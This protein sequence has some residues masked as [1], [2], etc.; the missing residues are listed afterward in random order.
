VLQAHFTDAGAAIADGLGE[1][2]AVYSAAG[3]SF[4]LSNAARGGWPREEGD[5]PTGRGGPKDAD[6]ISGRPA[7]PAPDEAAKTE[8][9]EARPLSLE[10]RRNN[11]FVIPE[12]RRP[13]ALLRFGD[14]D[15]L[16]L[17]GLLRHGGELARRAAVV[18]VPAGKGRLLLFAINPIWRGETIGTH[19]LVWNSV[20]EGGAAPASEGR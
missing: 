9:W 4:E 20:L 13:R 1:S 7:P 12:G 14:E 2:L 3:M 8:R 17:S 18:E 19:P 15:G 5:R 16:L 6:F 10:E 11:P